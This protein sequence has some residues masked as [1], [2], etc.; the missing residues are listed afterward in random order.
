MITNETNKIN[1]TN[2]TNNWHYLAIKGIPGLL[3]GITSNH[4]EDFY[5]LNC[6]HSYTTEKKLRKQER[7][8]KDHDFCDIKMPDQDN[9]ILK[10]I[11]AEKS[12]R[13]P[14]TIYADLECLLR[15]INTCSNNP[16]KS[17]TEKKATHRPSAY[18]LVTCCSF[19]KSKNECNYYRG[20]DCMKM[21]CKGLKNQ[22]KK[23]INYEKKEMIPLTDEEKESYENQKICH[24]CE[25]EFSTDDKDKK[26]HKVRDHCHYTGKY[27]GAAHNN[28]NLRYKIPKEIPVVF[29]NGSTYDYHFIIKQLARE[30]KGDFECI[31]ENTEKYITFSVPIKKEHDNGKPSIYR[32]KLIDSCRFM[33]SSLSNLVD[34]LPEINNKGTKN[35]F[36]DSMRSMTDSLSQSIDKVLEI[37][38]KTSQNKFID[39]MRSM[40]FSLTQSIDKVSEIDRKISQIDKK[41][42]DNT[43]T[44][45][46]RSMINS[47]S[48][49]INK[50][51]EID[52]DIS[53]I[54]NKFTDNMR[55]TI[56]SMSQSI[57][58]ISG[59]NNKIL[60]DELIKK[61]PNTYQ[62]C[63]K[64]FN[65]FELLLRKGVY[66]CGYMDKW[67]KFKEESLPDKE[68][69]YSELNKE[70]ITDEDYAH[71]QKVW[72][73]FNIKNLG[74]YHDLYVQSDT[75]LLAD[76]FENF[77]GKC[78]EMYELDP[79][80]F[81]SAPGLAWQAC[82]KKT[83]VKLELLTD[84]DMLLMFDKGI[85]GGVCQVSHHYG[86]VNNKY[87]KNY[88]KKY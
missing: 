21:F 25:E 47:L 4:N 46:V 43:F 40:I 8:S 36:T 14:F 12:L 10:Y 54:D 55:P 42:P 29:H 75:L 20:K 7:I 81:L 57:D 45:S 61:F 68:S 74:E 28:C 63:N 51:S 38:N 16:D 18:S 23:I 39:N 85:R 35:K 17:Y 66:P 77:K 13:V 59:S 78:I 31:G 52:N 62:L 53:Q 48:Q 56:S 2:K 73:T 87:L 30:F 37:D 69:F 32:L 84:N 64:D 83:Q 9:K 82:L 86:K 72:N 80:Q 65:K 26:Y 6:F 88:D 22:A 49:S 50:V 34:D 11:S 60:Q 27:R 71:A 58:K 67:E 15:K 5:C 76:V 70:G 3:R 19:D 41:K 1:E 44:D 79:A 24:I 33:Q